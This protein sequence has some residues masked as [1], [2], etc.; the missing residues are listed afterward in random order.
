MDI[1]LLKLNTMRCRRVMTIHRTV[2]SRPKGDIVS[3]D[4]HNNW[5]N[6]IQGSAQLF[7]VVRRL[8]T[9]SALP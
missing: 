6:V 2:K 4:S 1:D 7:I 3:L 5:N 9:T 8:Q